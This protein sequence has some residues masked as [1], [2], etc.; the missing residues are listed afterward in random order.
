MGNTSKPFMMKTKSLLNQWNQ[1]IQQERNG[2]K[3]LLFLLAFQCN[4][5]LAED[6]YCEHNP[7]VLIPGCGPHNGWW[8]DRN[9]LGIHTSGPVVPGVHHYNTGI[10]HATYIAVQAGRRGMKTKYQ[11]YI[12]GFVSGRRGKYGSYE[13]TRKM[14]EEEK[15]KLAKK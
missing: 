15:K 4:C 9:N 7:H 6:H 2:M 8:H 1:Q 13:R 12:P 5:K 14:I 3:Y 10:N 11:A